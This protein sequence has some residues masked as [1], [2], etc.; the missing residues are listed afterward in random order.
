MAAVFAA[1]GGLLFGYDTGVIS[2]A[3]LFIKTQMQL[4]TVAQELIVSMVLVGAAAGAIA[5]GK[6][7]DAIGRRMSLLLTSSIFIFG[8]LICAFAGSF[9]VLLAGRI[10]VGLGIVN[11]GAGIHLGNFASG[12]TRMAGVSVPARDYAGNPLG[13]RRELLICENC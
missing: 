1:V 7:S 4:S 8:A 6:L 12:G 3:I 2:G 11:H 10:I 13:V 9:G 5:G